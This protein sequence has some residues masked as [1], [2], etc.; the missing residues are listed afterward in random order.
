[1]SDKDKVILPPPRV[2]AIHDLSCFGRCALTVVI[3]TLSALGIQCIPMPTAL[4]STHTGGFSDMYIRD[5]STDMR[6][7][8]GH[9]EDLGVRF[10]AI[11]TGFILDASQGEIISEFVKKFRAEM[12]LCLVDP[13]MGDDGE[14]YSTCTHQ[15][16]DIMYSLCSMADIITPNLTE[17]CL[18]CSVEY[19][20]GG[21]SSFSECRDFVT[22]LTSSLLRL[23]P[24]VAITGIPMSEGKDEYIVTVAASREGAVSFYNE[25]RVHFSYHG[26]G[27]LFASILLGRV[28]GGAEFSSAVAVAS[29]FVAETIEYSSHID[30]PWREGTA[31]EPCLMRLSHDEYEK[32]LKG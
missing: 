32:K 11:Y 24:F 26:T 16:S 23:S 15:M 21:F 22:P 8:Y 14:L 12:T 25:K 10:D 3:P 29:R 6:G 18:L 31:L 2:C 19:P 13:V 1:M 28:L 7:I 20:R 17:A 30:T 5:L 9:W 4:L 27:E